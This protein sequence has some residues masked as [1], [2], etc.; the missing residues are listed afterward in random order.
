MRP[1]VWDDAGWYPVPIRSGVHACLHIDL[2]DAIRSGA[3]TVWLLCPKASL[4]SGCAQVVTSLRALLLQLKLCWPAGIGPED[5][6]KRL[7]DYG[8]HAPTMSWP[9]SGTLMIEPTES[10]S[11]VGHTSFCSMQ[12]RPT[13]NLKAV[14]AYAL[15]LLPHLACSRTAVSACWHDGMSHAAS[16]VA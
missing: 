13:G 9:V 7:I 3:E 15:Q 2:S 6:A 12:Q 8:F 4:Q 11:K 1:P 14:C 16:A 5:I 10:E